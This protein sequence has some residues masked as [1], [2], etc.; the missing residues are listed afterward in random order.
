MD[1]ASLSGERVIS[2]SICVPYWGAWVAD[3]V[4][5]TTATVSGLCTLTAGHL[6][7]TGYAVRAASFT[8]ARG[9]RL[10]GGYGGWRNAVTA[11]AYANPGGIRASTVLG[12]A[13]IEVGEKV[14][15]ASDS[16]IGNFYVR[17]AASASVVLRHVA[18]SLWWIDAS[19]TTQIGP[20]QST[21]IT[22]DLTV[23]SYS[24]AE[25][26]FILATEDLAAVVPGRT[27]TAPTVPQAV[28]ISGVIHELGNDGTARTTVLAT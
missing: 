15:I 20:R 11:R 22:S 21:P 1:F 12:D 19:G 16:T 23:V 2:A 24:G 6:S 3:V 7:L 9:V 25:G 14:S 28:T 13:A 10:V 17:P 4:L 8:G 5:A 27:F 26:R 18:G